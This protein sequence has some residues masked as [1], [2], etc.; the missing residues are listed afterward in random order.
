M[1]R[2]SMLTVLNSPERAA[3][4]GHLAAQM[5]IQV[6]HAEGAL[7]ALTQLERTPVDAIICDAQMPDM[8]G[9]EFCS[10]VAGDQAQ[11]RLPVYLIP[12][13]AAGAEDHHFLTLPAGPEVLARAF[14][15]LGLDMARSPVPL[16]TRI[17]P[18]LGGHLGTFGL[19]E[20]L[21]W[22]GELEFS[23]HWLITTRPGGGSQRTAHLAMNRGRVVYAEFGGLSGKRA[24]LSLLR[25]I[26]RHGATEFSFYRAPEIQLHS[27]GEF[28]Q[29]TARLLIELAVDLDESSVPAR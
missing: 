29:S 26:E 25:F 2:P 27:T 6:I 7:H 4:Y 10:V 28:T 18:E 16:N 15:Q 17:T 22:V 11:S 14:R 13:P 5:D 3:M 24:I 19:P 20:F 12:S 8:T 23:G 9:A 1:T 21:S